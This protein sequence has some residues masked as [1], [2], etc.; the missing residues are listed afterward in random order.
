L[1]P[2]LFHIIATSLFIF[3]AL[4]KQTNAK[5]YCP[6]AVKHNPFPFQAS[7]DCFIKKDGFIIQFNGI[8]IILRFIAG[9]TFANQRL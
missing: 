7:T 5:S 9:I 2:I 8:F 6:K 4:L 3:S 1:T